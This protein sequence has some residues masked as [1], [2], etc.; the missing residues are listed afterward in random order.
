MVFRLQEQNVMVRLYRVAGEQTNGGKGKNG[1]SD[2]N[3]DHDFNNQF[4]RICFC[5]RT[6]EWK[7]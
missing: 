4:Q 3:L 7:V 2:G 5:R 1:Q 6:T